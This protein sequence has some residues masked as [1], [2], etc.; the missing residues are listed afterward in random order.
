MPTHQ[1]HALLPDHQQAADRAKDR[2]HDPVDR[3]QAVHGKQQALLDDRDAH[4]KREPTGHADEPDGGAAGKVEEP[5]DEAEE[6]EAADDSR[7]D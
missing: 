7:E 1:P 4:A 3:V 6:E 5:E 2:S